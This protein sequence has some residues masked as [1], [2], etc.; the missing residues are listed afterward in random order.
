MTKHGH[1]AAARDDIRD[2][3]GV[4]AEV[5]HEGPGAVQTSRPSRICDTVDWAGLAAA[6]PALLV[7]SLTH[8]LPTSPL[9]QQVGNVKPDFLKKLTHLKLGELG[10]A[11]IE[12]LEA[13]ERL[14]NTY[15]NHLRGNQT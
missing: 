11:K 5:H 4:A 9:A 1:A 14:R 15:G 8:I 2:H 7:A 13:C 10:I 12:A 3:G 6:A